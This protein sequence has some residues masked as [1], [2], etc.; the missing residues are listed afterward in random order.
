MPPQPFQT[1]EQLSSILDTLPDYVF[2]TDVHTGVT[3]YANRAYIDLFARDGVE[4]PVGKTLSELF[5]P[6]VAKMLDSQNRQIAATGQPFRVLETIEAPKRKLYADT[7][8]APLYAADGYVYA[9]IGTSRDVTEIE[10]MRQTLTHRTE[11]LE[12]TNQLLIASGG[13]L[14]SVL[15]SQASSIAVI[16]ADGSIRVVNAR[17][18]EAALLQPNEQDRRDGIGQNYFTLCPQIV[19][20]EG[21]EAAELERGLRALIDGTIREF[22][23]EFEHCQSDGKRSWVE[24]R[25]SRFISLNAP[26]AV[27]AHTNITDRKAAELQTADALRREKEVSDMK[28]RFL[29][30]VAHEFRTPITIIQSSLDMLVYYGETMNAERR[31]SQ[32]HKITGQLK[33]LMT[34]IDEISFLYRMQNIGVKV[35][36]TSVAILPYLEQVISEVEMI[37]GREGDIQLI[38]SGLSHEAAFALDEL[39]LH[40]IFFNLVSN[41]VKYSSPGTPVTILVSTNETHLA[42]TIADRG[43]G[44]AGADLKRLF[45]PFFRGEN[46]E[47]R[48]GTG[49]GLSIVDQSVK[50]LNGQ[51]SVDSKIGEGSTFTVSFPF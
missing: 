37:H 34:L 2:V 38:T 47:Q 30:L 23:F 16:H 8:K 9:I 11:E 26:H 51:V 25:A 36:R 13:F 17:W 27:I 3:L 40:Q 46:V 39:L 31:A 7:Y 45:E 19:G 6:V 41:A 35:Q 44:I 21:Q 10:I 15:D 20:C 24:I 5:P 1:F 14:Q 22:T 33:R 50:A 32:V 18:R 4:S 28:S 42:V 48:S 49:L 43:I 29:S 12:Q